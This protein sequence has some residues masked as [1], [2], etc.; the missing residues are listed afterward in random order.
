[1]RVTVPQLAAFGVAIAM[2]SAC[3]TLQ[4]LTGEGPISSRIARPADGPSCQTQAVELRESNPFNSALTSSQ[5]FS[6]DHVLEKRAINLSCNVNAYTVAAHAE[7]SFRPVYKE[8]IQNPTER[9]TEEKNHFRLVMENLILQYNTDTVNGGRPQGSPF[10]ILIYA[11]GGLVDH[12]NAISRAQ[13]IAPAMIADGFAPIFVAWNS[14]FPQSYFQRLCCISDGTVSTAA[15]SIMV[16]FRLIG[17]LGEGVFRIPENTIEQGGRFLSARQATQQPAGDEL[18]NGD[19]AQSRDTDPDDWLA[20]ESYRLWP[21]RQQNGLECSPFMTRNDRRPNAEADPTDPRRQHGLAIRKCA[22]VVFPPVRGASRAEELDSLNGRRSSWVSRAGNVAML[23]VRTVVSGVSGAGASAWDGMVRRARLGFSREFVVH[24]T[25]ELSKNNSTQT[26][27]KTESGS[28]PVAQAAQ[29]PSGQGV[30]DASPPQ[31]GALNEVELAKAQSRCLDRMER[32]HPEENNTGSQT[33]ADG[34]NNPA[35]G[36]SEDYS[37]FGN[38]TPGVHYRFFERLNDCIAI[39]AFGRGTEVYVF[40]HSM[41]AIVA[42]ELV[43]TVPTLPYKTLVYMGGAASIR[44]TAAMLTRLQSHQP[45]ARFYNLTLHPVL[46]SIE[47]SE[48]LSA[49]SVTPRGS[50]LEWIDEMFDGPRDISDRTVGKWRNLREGSMVFPSATYDM[51]RI[52]V[53]PITSA[54]RDAGFFNALGCWR[55]VEAA[56]NAVARSPAKCTPERHGEFSRFSFWRPAFY[57]GTTTTDQ[58]GGWRVNANF[59]GP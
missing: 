20:E 53:F 54:N 35:S 11:H 40:G 23:P 30:S 21:I 24:Y 46:E 59:A 12:S 13:V 5:I 29:A 52:R 14:P 58:S 55:G 28:T 8:I 43:R 48:G 44:E 4:N 32:G 26:A 19:L 2:V 38:S 47:T 37:Y 34:Q 9:L 31:P 7:G 1:M 50:L 51:M 27:R 41:G 33:R 17:D 6:V 3:S 25:H 16:P 22:Q 45:Y 36:S 15:S 49:Q 10:R 42:N 57:T 56:G 18:A 39:G